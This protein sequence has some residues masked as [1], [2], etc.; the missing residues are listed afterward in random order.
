MVLDID[1][2]IEQVSQSD[3]HMSNLMSIPGIGYFSSALIKSEIINIARF[4]SF[5][6]LCAYAGLAPQVSASAKKTFH[7]PINKN[8]RKSLQWIILENVY[9]FIKADPTMQKKYIKLKKRKG[10]NTAKVALGREMLKI[11]YHV[12]KEERSYYV[13]KK[14]QSVVAPALSGV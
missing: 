2:D 1:K 4:A 3:L 7:G 8:R 14:I 5:S 13:K 11:I 10:H 12:L 6:R 9:H